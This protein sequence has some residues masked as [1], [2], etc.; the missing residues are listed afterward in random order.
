MSRPEPR[1]ELWRL[2]RRTRDW[3]VAK[4]VWASLESVVYW[5][6]PR[7]LPPTARET[8]VALPTGIRLAIPPRLS[9][10]QA[11]RDGYEPVST[12]WLTEFISPGWTVV[13]GGANIGYFTT[14]FSR[15]VGPAGRVVAFEPDPINFQYLLRNLKTNHCENVEPIHAA[16]SDESGTATFTPDRFLAEGHLVATRNASSRSLIVPTVRLED[17][18]RTRRLASVRLVK[19]DVEGGEVPALRG[20]AGVLE[21][22]DDPRVVFECSP[23]ALARAG[24]TV[25][26]LFA[27]LKQ[28]GFRYAQSVE[29][30]G[31]EFSLSHPPVVE[32]H[33]QNI[34]VWR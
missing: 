19:L 11:Y 10:G 7:L 14:L 22:G 30:A 1:E 8:E 23:R 24:F 3:L 16:L 31:P 18:L 5:A 26:D 2:G 32:G 28:L 12:R 21:W 4:H 25:I 29:P 33:S 20:M 34:V 27:V 17:F 15:C 6:G 13:D 9:A